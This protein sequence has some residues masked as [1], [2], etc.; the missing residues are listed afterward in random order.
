[1]EKIVPLW[2]IGYEEKAYT[3]FVAYWKNLNF[4]L[5]SIGRIQALNI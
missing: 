5:F 3:S 4:K 2:P 1:M